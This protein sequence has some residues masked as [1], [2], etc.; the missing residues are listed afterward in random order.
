MGTG[1]YYLGKIEELKGKF[2]NSVYII[3]DFYPLLL[4]DHKSKMIHVSKPNYISSNTF[5]TN[6]LELN[7]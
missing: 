3:Y 5:Y 1:Y 2:R 4:S 7:K 6:G